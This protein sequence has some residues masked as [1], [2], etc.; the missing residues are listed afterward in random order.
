MKWKSKLVEQLINELK[1]DKYWSDIVVNIEKN[2]RIGVHLAI[3][4][5]PFLSLIYKGEKKIESRFSVNRI[6]P[7]NKI[8]DGDIVI[9][10]ESGG[11]VS[12]IFLAGEVKYYSNLDKR[13]LK[14]IEKQYSSLICTQYSENFWQTKEKSNYATLIGIK[15][16]K[17]INPFKIEKNDRS[18][19]SVIHHRSFHKFT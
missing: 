16:I 9:L 19:W 5:E 13:T 4:N 1:F 3:F 15:K 18:G 2:K 7:Y 10:K 14:G 8:Y 11:P 17:K 12:G 6:A